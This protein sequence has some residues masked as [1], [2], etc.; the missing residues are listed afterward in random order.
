MLVIW[1]LQLAFKLL[2]SHPGRVGHG[3]D[4]P[5]DKVFPVYINP[6]SI[7]SFFDRLASLSS[8]MEHN[9][10]SVLIGK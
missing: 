8:P 9:Y 4:Y 6:A 5:D 3:T 10:P 2:L 7:N 1:N